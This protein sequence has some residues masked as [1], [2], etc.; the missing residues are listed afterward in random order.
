MGEIFKIILWNQ[1]KECP[2]LPLL[3]SIVLKVLTSIVNQEKESNGIS[4]RKKKKLFRND[5]IIYIANLK[6]STDKYLEITMFLSRWLPVK[7]INKNKLHFYTAA[8]NIRKHNF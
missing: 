8:I 3:F 6:E 4:I 2:P 7:S 5:V 1:E